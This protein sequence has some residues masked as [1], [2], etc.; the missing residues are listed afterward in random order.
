M[1]C[2]LKCGFR[3][4]GTSKSGGV[5][6]GTFVTGGNVRL[7]EPFTDRQIGRCPRVPTA[8]GRFQTGE[9]YRQGLPD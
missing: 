7:H 3:M 4:S 9:R 8:A 6:I 5:A 1:A 2:R